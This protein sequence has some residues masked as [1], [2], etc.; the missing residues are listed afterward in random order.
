MPLNQGGFWGN[1]HLRVPGLAAPRDLVF[2]SA[3]LLSVLQLLAMASL[4]AVC[5][6]V[7]SMSSEMT[8]L[9]WNWLPGTQEKAILVSS[10]KTKKD[11]CRLEES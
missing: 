10:L 8:S 3:T 7:A 4:C 5:H 11:F 1:S 6:C 9:Q 2:L